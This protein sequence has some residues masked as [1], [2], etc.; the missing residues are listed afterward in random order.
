ML[1]NQDNKGGRQKW[2]NQEKCGFVPFAFLWL[3]PA[4]LAYFPGLFFR[5]HAQR[6]SVFFQ[7]AAR[8]VAIKRNGL[9]AGRS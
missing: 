4:C 2:R 6:R 3:N 9:K 1:S 7:R 5:Q 8:H